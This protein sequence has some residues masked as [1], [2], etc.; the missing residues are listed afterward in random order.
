LSFVPMCLDLIAVVLLV[1]PI[2]NAWFREMQRTNQTVKARKPERPTP[3]S[4]PE[5]WLPP[6]VR[7]VPL[8]LSFALALVLNALMIVLVDRDA[9]YGQ[10]AGA[11]MSLCL[12]VSAVILAIGAWVVAR[13]AKK[14]GGNPW[15]WATIGVWIGAIPAIA[16]SLWALLTIGPGD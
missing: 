7:W 11:Y 8:A 5:K 15:K 4:S 10:L 3:R 6:Q 2:S 9:Y 12:P 13:M 14:D 16:L 1:L